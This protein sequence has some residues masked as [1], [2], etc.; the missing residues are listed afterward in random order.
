MARRSKE[1]AV[2]RHK[3][4]RE[5]WRGTERGESGRKAQSGG[6]VLDFIKRVGRRTPKLARARPLFPPRTILSWCPCYLNSLLYCYIYFI[7]NIYLY[8]STFFLK[9]RVGDDGVPAILQYRP[10]DLYLT[11]RKET[12]AILQ[13]DTHSP[14]QICKLGLPSFILFSHKINY[15]YK[16]ILMFR[17]THGHL[18]SSKKL[19][20]ICHTTGCR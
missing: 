3:A 1:R 7:F 15:S 2:V 12:M 11:D 20:I 10:S 19:S 16:C 18:A 5:W 9:N 4:R 8:F 14:L 6:R 17:A 13:K